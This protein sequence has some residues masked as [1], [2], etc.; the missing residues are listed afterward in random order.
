MADTLAITATLHLPLAE[1]QMSAT[2]A[3]GAGGQHVNKTES[4][5]QL[6]FD[7]RASSLP[8]PVR[9]RALKLAGARL[10]QE[11]VIVIKAQRHRSQE[12]NRAD[13]LERLRALLEKAAHVPRERRATKP[14]RASKIRR[15][16]GK[17]QRGRLKALRQNAS[18]E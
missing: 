15:V 16:E 10:A 11:D 1:V 18:D 14:T 3:Q 2:R 13:A 12:M 9:E 4:A 7:V 5:I 8:G 6:R 17:T